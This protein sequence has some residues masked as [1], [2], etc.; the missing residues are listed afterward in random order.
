MTETNQATIER[1]LLASPP[2]QFDIILEDLRSL[3]PKSSSQSLLEPTVV[4]TLR[5]EWEASTGR[6]TLNAADGG[7]AGSEDGDG[8][9]T[10]LSKAMDNY[11]AHKFSSPGVRA[12]HVVTA[13][14]ANDTP[15]F[16]IATYA[17]RIDL[18][19]HHAGSWKG[20]YTICPSSGEMGGNISVCAHTFENG[21]NVQLHSDISLEATNVE[22]YSPSDGDAEG[23]LD[24]AKRVTSQIDCWEEEKLMQNLSSMYESMGNTYLKSLRRVMPITR[25][26]MEWNVMAHRVV[27]TLGEGH[28]KDKFKH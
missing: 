21:G 8:F 14:T 7:G 17:E 19:N 28:D 13:T 5:S 26:K 16:T 10:S 3:L 11:L 6:S 4:S 22:T 20:C 1:L 27:Q 23:Q 9:I 25:T 24:W 12:A 18:H 2:G 15:T